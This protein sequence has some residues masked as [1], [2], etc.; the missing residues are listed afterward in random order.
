MNGGGGADPIYIS[1]PRAHDVSPM[2]PMSTWE[3]W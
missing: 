3:L 2:G 1:G